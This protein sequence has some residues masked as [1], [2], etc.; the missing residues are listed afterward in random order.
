MLLKK[1]VLVD[2]NTRDST[3]SGD[4][5]IEVE[6]ESDDNSAEEPVPKPK[7]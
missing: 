4:K 1:V 7:R 3:D 6:P 2:S 5:V